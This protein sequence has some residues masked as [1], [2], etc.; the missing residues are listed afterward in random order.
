MTL[1]ALEMC[2]VAIQL[3]I[4]TQLGILCIQLSHLYSAPKLLEKVSFKLGH[5]MNAVFSPLKKKSS[6]EGGTGI[7]VRR[8]ENVRVY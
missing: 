2:M 7:R 8:W 1:A 3:A 5:N 4:C 6:G